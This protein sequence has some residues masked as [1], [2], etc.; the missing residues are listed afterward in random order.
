MSSTGVIGQQA[1]FHE[2]ANSV[3]SP[4]ST[5]APTPPVIMHSQ[6]YMHADLQIENELPSVAA[7]MEDR[8]C[9]VNNYSDIS[10]EDDD[11][12]VINR[13]IFRRPIVPKYNK[14]K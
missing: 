2:A 9:Q 3:H 13:Q 7:V 4:V 8:N 10:D 11:D 12:F 14:Q 6:T 1:I 5:V